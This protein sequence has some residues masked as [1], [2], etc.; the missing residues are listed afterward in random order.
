[1]VFLLLAFPSLHF[2]ELALS[3]IKWLCRIVTAERLKWDKDGILPNWSDLSSS[4]DVIKAFSPAE[5]RMRAR[6]TALACYRLFSRASKK[7]KALPRNRFLAVAEDFETINLGTKE[8]PKLLRI[9][10]CLSTQE[11]EKM[12]QRLPSEPVIMSFW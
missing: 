8:D 7:T 9:G 5:K 6:A 10:K 11:R 1:M 12:Y 3:Y 2:L 4:S